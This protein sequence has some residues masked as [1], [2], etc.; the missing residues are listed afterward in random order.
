M[1]H[2]QFNYLLQIAKSNLSLHMIG[3]SGSG[4]TTIAKQ[5]A[6]ELNLPFNLISCT[7]MMSVGHLLGFNTVNGVYS[8]TPFRDAVENGGVFLLDERNAADPNTL[9]CL[10]TIRNGFVAFPDKRVDVHPDFILIA[11]SN[12]ASSKF[13]AR[14]VEDFSTTNRFYNVYVDVDPELALALSS[15]EAMDQV[16]LLRDFFLEYGHDRELTMADDILLHELMELGLDEQPI[17]RLIDTESQDLKNAFN[18]YLDK[19]QTKSAE[20]RAKRIAE[21]K[22]AAQSQHDFDTID[23]VIRKV[24]HEHDNL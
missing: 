15:Q 21:A 23:E 4:K 1:K 11:A 10:N 19:H 8:G 9:L 5:I 18:V 24:Q 6:D 17:S 13:G 3:P 14:D 16:Q 7:R 20:L 22:Y 12:P 2:S